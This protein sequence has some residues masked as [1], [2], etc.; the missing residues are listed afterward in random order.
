VLPGRLVNGDVKDKFFEAGGKLEQVQA[1][2]RFFYE[3]GN[4]PHTGISYQEVLDRVQLVDARI[5]ERLSLDETK[6]REVMRDATAKAVNM[7]ML[8]AGKYQPSAIT[9]VARL[10]RDLSTPL[11]A[12]LGNVL[13]PEL[14]GGTMVETLWHRFSAI[15]K[16]E[17]ALNTQP[18]DLDIARCE[19]SVLLDM[20]IEFMRKSF[21]VN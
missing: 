20:S 15:Y 2:L 8:K 11:D 10:C 4:L 9:A 3:N 17:L 21:F 12:I 19:A 7:V 16:K 5:K 13:V 14:H 6:F 18:S 1:H